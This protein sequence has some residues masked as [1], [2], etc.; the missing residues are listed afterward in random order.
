MIIIII[1]NNNNNN[2][3]VVVVVDIIIIF[4]IIIIIIIIITI[5]IINIMLLS[6]LIDLR[7][8]GTES[9]KVL[10]RGTDTYYIYLV[11]CYILIAS[12]YRTSDCANFDRNLR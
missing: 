8:F 9:A 2:I 4:V 3:I 7:K 6:N 12:Y 1:I 11:R 5:T 10:V